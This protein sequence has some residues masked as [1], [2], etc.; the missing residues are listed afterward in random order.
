MKHRIFNSFCFDLDKPAFETNDMLKK[1]FCYDATSRTQ[2][3]EWQSHLR[4]S[5]SLVEHFECS[6]QT[7]SQTDENMEKVSSHP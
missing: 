6:G 2:T 5:L 7:S 1:N 4:S 3:S